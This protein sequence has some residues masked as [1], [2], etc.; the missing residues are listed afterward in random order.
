MKKLLLFFFILIIFYSIAY[1]DN[2]VSSE[3]LTLALNGV[4]EISIPLHE[5]MIFPITGNAK[6]SISIENL[7]PHIINVR[8]DEIANNI[9]IKGLLD[10]QGSFVLVRNGIRKAIYVA[11]RES[12]GILPERVSFTVTGN[13]AT[14]DFLKDAALRVILSKSRLKPNSYLLFDEYVPFQGPAYLSR[15]ET[16]SF[17]IPVKIVSSVYFPVRENVKVDVTNKIINSSEVALL[18]ISN[19]PEKIEEDG[20]LFQEELQ[21]EKPVRLLYY[22]QNS[23]KSFEREFLIKFT[24]PSRKAID[25]K[26]I[27]GTSGPNSDVFFVGHKATVR[28]MEDYSSDASQIITIPPRGEFVLCKSSMK[29]GD[30]IGG[31]LEI[32]ILN[33]NPL[34]VTVQA[35]QPDIA[36]SSED[37]LPDDFDPFR[38]HPKGIFANPNI[39]SETYY[40]VTEGELSIPF[41][42]SPWLPDIRTGAPNQGN[43]GVIYKFNI[44]LNN[45]TSESKTV[46]LYFSPVNGVA[47]GVLIINGILYETSLLRPGKTSIITDFNLSPR[48]RRSLKIFTTPQSGSAYPVKLIFKSD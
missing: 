21:P 1:G 45:S 3:I 26:L 24:N 18:M 8:A 2:K 22:H 44:I 33:D 20:I 40:N 35:G 7:S 5:T 11:V 6:G 34:L 37:I 9:V 31:L 17:E 19:R 23:P 10:G 32:H 43:Y 14:K 36:M 38:I 41:G 29:P 46:K 47:R 42:V 25:I 48:E 30:V 13:P 12:A 15:G 27:S 28:F 4:N 39:S 16:K